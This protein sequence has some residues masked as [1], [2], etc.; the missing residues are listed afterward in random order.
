MCELSYEVQ[1]SITDVLVKKTLR[2]VETYNATSILIGGGV[3]ANLR[4]REKFQQ[5]IEKEHDTRIQFFAPPVALSTDNAAYIGSYAY[6]RGEPVDWHT[7][8]AAP[9]LSVEI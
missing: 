3:S 9:G 5:T 8:E 7:I 1:E 2:A 6:Y 4:L